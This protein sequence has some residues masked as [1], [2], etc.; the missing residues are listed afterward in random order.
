MRCALLAA[1]LAF[2]PAARADVCRVVDVD[3]TPSDEL[4]IVGW[5]EKPDGTFVDTIYITN[6]VGL[7]G[8]GNRPGRFDFNSGPVV[9][10]MAPYG[11]RI[12]TFPVW[13]HRHGL[14]WPEVVFQDGIESSPGGSPFSQASVETY[15]CRPINPQEPAWD[16]GTCPSMIYTDKGVFSATATSL[17]PPRADIKRVR[18][19]DSPSVDLYKQMNPF[20]AV[21]QATPTGGTPTQIS[22]SVPA[23]LPNGDYVAWLE[24]A[25]AFDFNA[26]YNPTT[27]PA[28]TDIPYGDYG[29]PYRGQPSVVYA[30]HF[31]LGS[32][33]TVTATQSYT[34]YSDPTGATGALNP[35]DATIT[36]DTPASGASRLQLIAGSADRLRACAR[37]ATSAAPPTP[38]VDLAPATVTNHSVM[39]QFVA[40]ATSVRTCS[41]AASPV[42]GYEVRY[43][44]NDELT[45]ANFASSSLAPVVLAPSP[46]GTIQTFE[47]DGLLPQT[48]YWIGIRAY[49]DC[50]SYSDLAIMQ[51]T[52]PAQASGDVDACFVATAAYGSLMANDVELLRSFRDSVLRSTVFGELAVETYYTFSPPVA[53]V[54]GESELLRATARAALRPV[55]E[56]VRATRL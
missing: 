32:S 39:V 11:R 50:R 4:Q 20:D 52:T 12:M 3:F 30:V 19:Y 21:T 29:E 47:V 13:A 41:G 38:I 45:A 40:P 22:W 43:R 33:I 53:G 15:Y 49:D 6:K 56:R 35:P 1:L 36:T 14:T 10:D 5:I 26:A 46:A 25:K 23:S 16:T 7:Y 34:G 44:A 9:H 27:Y 18:D 24:V 37:P 28:P 42:A 8:L 55:I 51:V 17:Y 2:A 54:V 31:T 48:E